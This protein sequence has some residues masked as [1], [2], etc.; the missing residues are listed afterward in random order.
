MQSNISHFTFRTSHSKRELMSSF[1]QCAT[2][3]PISKVLGEDG[4]L[5]K[6][7]ALGFHGVEM[8]PPDVP[9]PWFARASAGFK[10]TAETTN[11][12]ATA[13]AV[14]ARATRGRIG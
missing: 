10:L 14:V 11:S 4:A 12:A 6:V 13:R 2:W 5:E 7:K 8:P 1:K 3:W 9:G